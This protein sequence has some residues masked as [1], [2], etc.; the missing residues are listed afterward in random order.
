[1][2]AKDRILKIRRQS[3]IARP[4]EKLWYFT[5]ENS[6]FE[7]NENQIKT[8][9]ND[10]L[11]ILYDDYKSYSQERE[12]RNVKTKDCLFVVDWQLTDVF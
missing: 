3:L 2:K 12:K 4:K 9:K 7:S 5:E 8:K 10:R 11:S 6:D 1:M